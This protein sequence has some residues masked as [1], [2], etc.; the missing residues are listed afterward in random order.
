[1]YI[2]GGEV[3]R[4]FCKR[5]IAREGGREMDS[6][7]NKIKFQRTRAAVASLISHE[8]RENRKRGERER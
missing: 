6:V 7:R 4:V 5:W 2:Y 8:K 1:M 3:E